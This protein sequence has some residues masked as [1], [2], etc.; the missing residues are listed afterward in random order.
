MFFAK[1]TNSFYDQAIH[2]DVPADA[3][4]ITQEHYQYL[5]DQV[6]VGKVI[7]VNSQREVVAVDPAPPTPEEQRLLDNGAARAYLNS[8]DWYVTRFTETGV[9]VPPE[10]TAAR[11]EARKSIVVA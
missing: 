6:S 8:T 1:S 9:P 7:D 4:Q 3:I 2:N 5:M 10:I 11:E